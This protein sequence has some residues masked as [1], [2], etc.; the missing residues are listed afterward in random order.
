MGTSLLFR[1][2]VHPSIIR[3]QANGRVSPRWT[4]MPWRGHHLASAR[5]WS[6]R[7]VHA[8]S[9][10]VH[11]SSVAGSV[12]RGLRL[13]FFPSPRGYFASISNPLWGGRGAAVTLAVTLAVCDHGVSAWLS[14]KSWASCHALGFLPCKR[15]MH[16]MG[17]RHGGFLPLLG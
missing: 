17:R 5:G 13:V 2:L 16:G 8:R 14:H 15:A 12:E 1:R 6:S 10:C 3:P 11:S 9:S 4:H 7:L